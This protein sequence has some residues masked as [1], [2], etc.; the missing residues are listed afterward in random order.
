MKTYKQR[1]RPLVDISNHDRDGKLTPDKKRTKHQV[2]ET[3]LSFNFVFLL[4]R[5]LTTYFFR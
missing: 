1:K 2:R 3:P 4:N 5:A